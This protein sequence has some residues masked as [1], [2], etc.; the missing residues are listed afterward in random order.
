[1]KILRESLLNEDDWQQPN[2]ESQMVKIQ[3]KSIQED[4]EELLQK[5]KAGDQFDAWVQAKIAVAEHSLSAVRDYVVL[6]SDEDEVGPEIIT[7]LPPMDVAPE[8][9]V[10]AKTP[11]DA[12]DELDMEDLMGPGPEVA[13]PEGDV[14]SLDDEGDDFDG[15]ME[16]AEEIPL[17]MEDEEEME[18]MVEYGDEHPAQRWRE[19]EADRRWQRDHHKMYDLDDELENPEDY[20]E[21]DYMME[22]LESF[23]KKLDK[24]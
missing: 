22:S 12:E 11:V 23:S 5:I 10:P 15:A 13:G 6:G 17:D 19:Q 24:S 8:Q 14:M 9:P 18:E 3:L 7:D 1:M 20:M 4:V 2:D 21:E 16:P